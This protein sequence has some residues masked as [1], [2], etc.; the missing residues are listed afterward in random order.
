MKYIL[1]YQL[2]EK[3][4]NFSNISYGTVKQIMPKDM[5]LEYQ[6]IIFSWGDVWKSPYSNSF[7]NKDKKWN[8]THTNTIR[9]S[10]HWNFTSHGKLHSV[11]IQPVENN[12]HY[13]MGIWNEIEQK[14][15]IISSYPKVRDN[16]D[17]LEWYKNNIYIHHKNRGIEREAEIKDLMD[18]ND[19]WI[20]YYIGGQRKFY[21]LD[22]LT[23]TGMK[24]DMYDPTTNT[25]I[26]EK[27]RDMK[28][29]KLYN[30]VGDEFKKLDFNI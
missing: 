22:R 4:I 17:S 7:Y 2:F 24:I 26:R 16:K 21:K 6:K 8:V 3:Y 27:K 9:I 13:S 23:S 29:K 1:S 20:E 18:N 11:T 10:D 25:K 19:I 14:Y 15:D 5:C 28:D 12:T 30:R